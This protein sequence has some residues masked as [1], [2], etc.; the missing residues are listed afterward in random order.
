MNVLAN[1]KELTW[2][3]TG[4]K[5][6]ESF[7]RFC[8]FCNNCTQPLHLLHDH[9]ASYASVARLENADVDFSKA[10]QRLV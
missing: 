2:A 9:N 1:M 8:S 6:K 10:D 4:I 5:V 3:H 7:L